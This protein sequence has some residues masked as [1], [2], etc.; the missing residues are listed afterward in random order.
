MLAAKLLEVLLEES[1]HGNDA[2]GHALD[3]TKP[4]LVELGVIQDLR[5]NAGTVNRRVG[6][7]WADENLDL[8]VDTLLLFSRLA[9]DGESANTLAVETLH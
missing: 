9:D 3:L 2:V 1:T 6:V 7:Q 8:R 4:L 5:G